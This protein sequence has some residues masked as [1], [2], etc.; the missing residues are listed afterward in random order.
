MAVS[1]P[2]PGISSCCCCFLHSGVLAHAYEA[3][4]RARTSCLAHRPLKR[5]CSSSLKR[6]MSREVVVLD[7]FAHT[8]SKFITLVLVG[9][10]LSLANLHSVWKSF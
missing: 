6:R 3:V 7:P 4:V 8:L 9:L 5:K 10:A 1:H 2:T